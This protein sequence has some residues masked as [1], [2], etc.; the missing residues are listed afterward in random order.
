M[1]RCKLL[2]V[3]TDT[4]RIGLTVVRG[5]I[6]FFG[7]ITPSFGFLVFVCRCL[8]AQAHLIF[9]TDPSGSAKSSSKISFIRIVRGSNWYPETVSN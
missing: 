5:L 2:H 7:R 9:G 4:Q 3:V 6:G 1:R 8:V